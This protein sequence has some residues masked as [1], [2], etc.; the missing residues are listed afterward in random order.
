MGNAPTVVVKPANRTGGMMRRA[1]VHGSDE[2]RFFIESDRN[3]SSAPQPKYDP[4]GLDDWL[5]ATQRIF[6]TAFLGCFLTVV[7]MIFL[8]PSGGQLNAAT[9]VFLSVFV[10]LYTTDTIDGGEEQKSTE[11]YLLSFLMMIESLVLSF[12]NTNYSLTYILAMLANLI[13]MFNGMLYLVAAKERD[14]YQLA[15]QDRI[16]KRESRKMLRPPH[17]SKRRNES[18]FGEEEEEDDE[19]EDVFGKEEE[20]E[21]EENSRGM[22]WGKVFKNFRTA[23]ERNRYYDVV[24]ISLMIALDLFGF[25]IVWF[26]CFAYNEFALDLE[27][28]ASPP[29]P[30]PPPPPV[31]ERGGGFINSRRR[32]GSS[33]RSG[34]GSEHGSEHGW[35]DVSRFILRVFYY[36]GSFTYISLCVIFNGINGNNDASFS[37]VSCWLLLSA[38]LVAT[39]IKNGM[40]MWRITKEARWFSP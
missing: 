25:N 38:L 36:A 11:L 2:D 7:S 28:E 29:P 5:F 34:R 12:L 18:E 23:I 15:Q 26:Y 31:E 10:R 3:A 14:Q 35:E 39:F 19:E 8:F 27:R 40:T 30:P 16:R 6:Y 4:R 21:D 22:D 37:H 33:R 13:L 9:M 32:N 17:H 1:K 24:A 20:E